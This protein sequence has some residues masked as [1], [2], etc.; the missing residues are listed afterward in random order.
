MIDPLGNRFEQYRPQM[1]NVAYRMLGSF[2]DAEDAVQD[3]WLRLNRHN[4]DAIDN[5]G[6]WLATVVSRICFD[7][8]RAR[9][10]KAEEPLEPGLP[11]FL[12]SRGA[13]P[14]EEAVAVDSLGLAA[15]IVLEALS[16]QSVLPSSFTICSQ[17][18]SRR[19]L[20]S[21]TARK[22]RRGSW[23]AGHGVAFARPSRRRRRSHNVAPSSPASCK[24]RETETSRSCSP[25][26]IPTSC[27]AQTA[28]R[29]CG[30]FEEP[31][32]LRRRRLVSR[33]SSYRWNRSSST[34]V[35]GILAWLPDG[36]PLS[37]MG[38][39]VDGDRIARMYV[40]S[41]PERLRHILARLPSIRHNTSTTE[42][43]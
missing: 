3:A 24:P 29:R 28:N 21:S 23:R 36:K 8:L 7:L 37:V 35:P 2:D 34:A 41:Q 31:S 9:R 18:R 14:E 39:V 38:F 27:Y 25:Y 17:C 13:N 11:D 19:S 32:P 12:V 4:D 43:T 42:F 33:A 40:L 6:G 16:P 20:R 22:W 10:S 30:A 26:W 5:I 1:R 15:T